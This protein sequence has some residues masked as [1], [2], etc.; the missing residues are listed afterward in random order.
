MR[1]GSFINAD[2]DGSASLAL[3][4]FSYPFPTFPTSVP[5]SL[6][7]LLFL[8]ISTPMSSARRRHQQPTFETSSDDYRLDEP[9]KSPQ[10]RSAASG[11]N[12]SILYIF[13]VAILIIGLVLGYRQM[14]SSTPPGL[15]KAIFNSRLYSTIQSLWF[16]DVPAGATVGNEASTKKWFYQPNADEK[17]AFDN[18]CAQVSRPALQEIGPNR[19]RLPPF[20]NFTLERQMA[21]NLASPL[22]SEIDPSTALSAD[23]AASNALSLILLLDQLSRNCFRGDQAAPV[24][25]HYDRLAQ[26]LIHHVLASQPRLDLVQKY[27]ALPVYRTWFYMP[28]MHSEH[29][30]DHVLFKSLVTELKADMVERGDEA[31][32]E[33]VETKLGYGRQHS[34]IIERFGRYPYRNQVLG[35]ESTE[36]E[37]EWLDERGDPF[38]GSGQ[39]SSQRSGM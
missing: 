4:S 13:T 14:P 38:G 15:N 39:S 36:A 3:S 6:Y 27:R 12:D 22:M 20:S 21:R 32:V 7:P 26:A 1:L 24:Y 8:S 35:R 10:S 2:G 23:A 30:E 17:A 19:L 16:A 9:I 18:L 28:L 29:V 31:A 37:R 33:D 25:A 11:Q 5:A 34:E